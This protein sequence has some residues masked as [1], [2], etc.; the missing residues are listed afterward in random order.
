[1]NDSYFDDFIFGGSPISKLLD[2]LKHANSDTTMA[3]LEKFILR[4]ATIEAML[5]SKGISEREI[6]VFAN[7]EEEK[8]RELANSLALSVMADILTQNE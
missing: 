6:A 1:M 5:D 7:E 8:I 3:E 4:A 2:V